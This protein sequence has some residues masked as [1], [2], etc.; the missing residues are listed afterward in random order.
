[1]IAEKPNGTGISVGF[2][3][4]VVPGPVRLAAPCQANLHWTI[5]YA[6]VNNS[7]NWYATTL[8]AASMTGTA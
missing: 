6:A 3:I 1:M 7:V 5:G 4:C 8:Q 2:R